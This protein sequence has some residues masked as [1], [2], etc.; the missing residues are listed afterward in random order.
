VNPHLLP[1]V[2][3]EPLM[4]SMRNYPCALRVSSF[5]PGHYCAPQSTVVGCHIGGLGKGV[6]TKTTDLAVA[7]GCLHCHQ[8]IDGVDRA[9]LDWIMAKYPVAFME[10]VLLGLIETH[11]RLV[12]DGIIR[13]KGYDNAEHL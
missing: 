9:K 6:A 3:S 10:R 12:V 7:A 13:V 2:R 5:Y 4:Q 1:K 11:S 8:I